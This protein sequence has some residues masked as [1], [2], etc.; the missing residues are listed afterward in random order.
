LQ[1][2]STIAS[3]HEIDNEK[4]SKKQQ[5]AKPSSMH[6]D[7]TLNQVTGGEGKGRSFREL[8]DQSDIVFSGS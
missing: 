5:F 2:P 3:R 1:K 8:N 7:A 4:D 6:C